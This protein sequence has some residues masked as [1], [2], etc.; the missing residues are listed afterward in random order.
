[1]KYC[2]ELENLLWS[3]SWESAEKIL[4]FTSWT[5]FQFSLFIKLF[6]YNKHLLQGC[7]EILFLYNVSNIQ[8]HSQKKSCSSDWT[9]KDYFTVL[10]TF[11]ML[12]HLTHQ[13]HSAVVCSTKSYCP[14]KDKDLTFFFFFFPL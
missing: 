2:S 8:K 10:S 4:S 14:G 13:H 9:E 1:M 11:C 6:A 12:L 5:C 7:Y 3:L